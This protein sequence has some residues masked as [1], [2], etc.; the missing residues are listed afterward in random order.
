MWI[1]WFS[2]TLNHQ[3]CLKTVITP[4]LSIN[5][6]QFYHTNANFID[7]ALIPAPCACSGKYGIIIGTNERYGYTL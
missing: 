1:L 5:W 4:L 6:Y 2:A 7:P 3:N